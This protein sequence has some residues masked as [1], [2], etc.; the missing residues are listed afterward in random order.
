MRLITEKKWLGRQ[1]KWHFQILVWRSRNLLMKLG[2]GSFL[3]LIT[4][5]LFENNSG[6]VLRTLPKYQHSSFL[7]FTERAWHFSTSPKL[8]LFKDLMQLK[9][10]ATLQSSCLYL[11]VCLFIYLK[12]EKRGTVLRTSW[13]SVYFCV[14]PRLKALSNFLWKIPSP[15]KYFKSSQVANTI[16]FF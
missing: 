11:F 13:E 14:S 3:L 16:C 2:I 15:Y 12:S 10:N 7:L 5:E 8:L 1:R 6:K 9:L 4:N